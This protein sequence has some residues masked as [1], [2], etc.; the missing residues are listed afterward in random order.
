M[1]HPLPWFEAFLTLR[2]K[3][4]D[5]PF[6]AFLF[7]KDL[8]SFS[9]YL[10]RSCVGVQTNCHFIDYRTF[11]VLLLLRLR[12]SFPLW[13]C[14]FVPTKPSGH[15]SRADL[16][17]F[18]ISSQGWSYFVKNV[19]VKHNHPSVWT[20]PEHFHDENVENLTLAHHLSATL[21]IPLWEMPFC[22]WDYFSCQTYFVS[23]VFRRVLCMSQSMYVTV[24]KLRCKQHFGDDVGVFFTLRNGQH[25]AFTDPH[26]SVLRAH[27]TRSLNVSIIYLSSEKKP[28]KV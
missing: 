4:Q 20:A 28:T 19:H 11:Q 2:G 13:R 12:R 21:Y 23:G 1:R 24:W 14:R 17:V 3:N 16:G 15:V 22:F 5:P 7:N 9:F 8:S 18:A 27:A 25:S 26:L 10:P 6:L